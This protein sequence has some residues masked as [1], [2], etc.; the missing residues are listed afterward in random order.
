[1]T[2]KKL[3][4][5]FIPPFPT[6]KTRYTLVAAGGGRLTGKNTKE[7]IATMSKLLLLSKANLFQTV[8]K[9]KKKKKVNA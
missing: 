1:M 3:F 7:Q 9:K 4:N 2:L 6:P 5:T 8:L